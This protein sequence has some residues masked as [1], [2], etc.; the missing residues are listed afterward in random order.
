MRFTFATA[1]FATAV[2]AK[3]GG[4]NQDT[5]DFV[6]FAVGQG[7]NYKNVDSFNKHKKNFRKNHKKVKQM[8]KENKKNN[9]EFGDNWTSD[10]D[11]VEFKDYLGLE[12]A[13]DSEGARLLDDTFDKEGRNL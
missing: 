5:D 7:K 8:N 12:A 3:N 6:K 10:M 9:I 11:E 13:D 1:L 2:L 4:D